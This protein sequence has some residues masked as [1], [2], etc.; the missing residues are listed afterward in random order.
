MTGAAPGSPGAQA[1]RGRGCRPEETEQMDSDRENMMSDP[2][3]PT[4]YLKAGVDTERE[5]RVLSRLVHTASQTFAFVR[6]IGKPV[7]PIGFFANVLD[8]GRGAGL[9]LSTDGVGTKIIIA[10]M[11]QKYDTLGID[12]V[13]M[14]ANDVLCVGARPLSFLDSLAG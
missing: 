12:C 13:A 9:A 2:A 4:N 3:G 14:N 11:M 5:E 1:G 8:L 7:L 6:D 10:Q